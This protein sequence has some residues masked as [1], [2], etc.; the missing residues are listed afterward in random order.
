EL[1]CERTFPLF[2]TDMETVPVSVH[3]LHPR[4]RLVFYTDGITERLNHSGSMFGLRRLKEALAWV[5]SDGPESVIGHVVEE[6]KVFADGH[7][8]D[9][10]QTLLLASLR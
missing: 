5:G 7:E 1:D 10:D 2:V 8:P 4:D 3:A 9:D 6:M